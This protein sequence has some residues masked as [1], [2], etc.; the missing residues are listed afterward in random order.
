LPFSLT[1]IITGTLVDLGSFSFMKI[2]LESHQKKYSEA[3]V[4]ET[5]ARNHCLWVPIIL[6]PVTKLL[7]N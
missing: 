2:N 6:G 4:A 7:L 1:K 5:V 3:I